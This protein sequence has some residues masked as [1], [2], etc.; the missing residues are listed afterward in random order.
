MTLDVIPTSKDHKEVSTI[1]HVKKIN[2]TRVKNLEVESWRVALASSA[3]STAP[4]QT[5]NKKAQLSLT[6]PRDACE[7]FAWFT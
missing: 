4:S 6:N 1:R 2:G 7:K 3:E 5:K